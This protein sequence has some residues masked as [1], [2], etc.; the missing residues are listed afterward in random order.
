M[1]DYRARTEDDQR[2]V[3]EGRGAKRRELH[4]DDFGGGLSV[5]TEQRVDRPPMARLDQPRVP[6]LGESAASHT[7]TRMSDE[8]GGSEEMRVAAHRMVAWR[9][10]GRS[11][12]AAFGSWQPRRKMSMAKYG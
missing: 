7:H 2:G 8:S 10:G 9:F 1:A 3:G 12:R 5:G 11:I 6:A 4:L